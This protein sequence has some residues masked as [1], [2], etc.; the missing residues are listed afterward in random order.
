MAKIKSLYQYFT[1]GER[2]LLFVSVGLIISAFLLFDGESY[3]TLF[4]SL[5]GVT[6][7]IFNAKGNP[8]GQILIILFS[9]LYGIISFTFSYYG[10]MITYL[11]M[12]APMAVFALISWLKNPYKNNHAEVKINRLRRGEAM[13]LI[14]LAAIVTIGFYYILAAFKTNNLLPSTVSVT[15]SFI[16]AYLTFKRSI[17]FAVWYALNDIVLIILWSL[18]SI[19]NMSYISVVICF[20][21]FLVN[22]IY[23]FI[24]WTKMRRRQETDLTINV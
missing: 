9:V 19:V 20:S 11:G 17:Y 23:G 5:V 14:L 21:V 24:S 13:L 22:D 12:T 10:E 6:S 8:V 1:A 7:L 2:V 3:L 18:A 4:A 15:T 16:A